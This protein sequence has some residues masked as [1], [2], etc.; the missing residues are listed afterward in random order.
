MNEILIQTAI[1]M[2]AGVLGCIVPV[3]PGPP[4]VFLGALFYAYRTHWEQVSWPSLSILFL[5]MLV[6]S[7]SNLWLSFFG[8]RKS[9][10]SIWASVAAI[11]G[12]LVGLM[13]FS[14][15][16]L[17]IGSLGAIAAVEYSLH[18]DWKKVLKAGGGYLGGY[19]L[20]IAVELAVCLS[21]VAIFL[22][23]IRL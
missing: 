10:A 3:L 1:I 14:L 8:A 22:V 7:T 17:L 4:L 13:V 12:G 19:L 5:L 16:G 11:I 2:A 9:G 15:P 21:M 6:G 20:S 23:A 18:K